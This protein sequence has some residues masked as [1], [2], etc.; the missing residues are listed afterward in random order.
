MLISEPYLQFVVLTIFVKL[1]K[2]KRHLN[3]ILLHKFQT[4]FKSIIKLRGTDITIWNIPHIHVEYEEYS[5]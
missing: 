5:A 3:L 4:L 1:M 2:K